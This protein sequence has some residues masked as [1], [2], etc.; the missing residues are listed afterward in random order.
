MTQSAFVASL[1][2]QAAPL[3]A[4]VVDPQ[5]RPAPKR[6]SVYR[7]N[8]AA[9]LTRAMEASFPTVR[10]L[11]GPQFFAAMAVEFALQHPPK[12]QL[13]MQ[14]GDEFA[15]FLETFP[16]VKSTSHCWGL[17]ITERETSA[18]M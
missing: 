17:M 9:G 15:G 3:P 11:V 6:F 7:N 1:L 10:K 14:Y 8:V 5:G 4:G 12:S 2:D 18:R 16:P 13:L